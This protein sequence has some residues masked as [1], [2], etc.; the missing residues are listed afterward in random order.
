MVSN[1]DCEDQLRKTRLG[2]N[3]NLDPGFI[4]A[5]GEEGNDACLGDGGSALA[6]SVVS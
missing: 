2:Q 1:T 6:C 4:C 3:F 5:G